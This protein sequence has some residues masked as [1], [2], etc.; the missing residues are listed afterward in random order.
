MD[1]QLLIA[2]NALAVSALAIGMNL[3]YRP[4]GSIGWIVANAV[5]LVVGALAF[6]L[7]P[8]DIGIWV[9]VAFIPLVVAPVVFGK[10][11]Q[12]KAQAGKWKAAAQYSRYAKFCHPTEANTVNADLIAGIADSQNG[13]TTAL[14]VLAERVP[15]AYKSIV[16]AHEAWMRRD[17][18][19]VLAHTDTAPEAQ[20]LMK[21]LEIRALG[22]T[23]RLEAMVRA[24]A[25]SESRVPGASQPTTRLTVL[26]FT[27]R[28]AAVHAL[29]TRPLAAMEPEV[30]AYWSGIA[31][32][33]SRDAI[34][35]GRATLTTLAQS[36]AK[37]DTRRAVERHLATLAARAPETLSEPATAAV[38]LAEQRV[39]AVASGET[40]A[41]KTFPL[42]LSLIGLNLAMFGAELYTGSSEDSET[43]ISLG[44][45]WP[46]Y[47]LQGREWWRLVSASFLHFGPIHLLTNMF[48][49]WVLGRAFEPTLGRV[50]M[51]VIYAVG[52]IAS[53]AFVLWLMW[54]GHTNY[55]LLVGASG[56]IFALLGAEAATVF[57]EWLGDRDNFDSRKL[58][59]LLMMLGLQIVIDVSLPNV[60]FAAHA[61]GFVTGM[62]VMLAWPYVTRLG[63]SRT[64][65]RNARS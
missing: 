59:S 9:A 29:L 65:G 16:T 55:G 62:A 6:W 1:L 61:S 33:Y 20:A 39:L 21:P 11:A 53:S 49:L 63:Q 58:T 7:V 26:A 46:P 25:Q 2:I 30:K 32:L 19:E 44:A 50:R 28:H 35:S 23:G 48:V 42:T 15:D 38:N 4:F 51:A 3:V 60:S 5:V 22:E 57:W 40:T 36:T 43:L 27:G 47:V 18:A 34:A 13:D 12:R 24:F 41:L 64:R 52:G 37:H 45:L 14:R 31:E 56:A 54:A 8:D 10:L 17:W